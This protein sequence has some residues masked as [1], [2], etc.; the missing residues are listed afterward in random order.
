MILSSK[1]RKARI[2]SKYLQK[3]YSVYLSARAEGGKNLSLG[4]Y[5]GTVI[6][7]VK[8]GENCT[9][10]HNVTIGQNH[11]K[12]PVIG[13]GVTIYA[14]AKVIGDIAIGDNA[15]IGANSVVINDVPENSVVAGVPAKVIRI[16]SSASS[17]NN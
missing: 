4:H 5:V 14:G 10:Y 15:I 12:S 7:G 6:G 17:T 13:N 16:R 11:G 9:I 8:I 3:K 2:L 1:G